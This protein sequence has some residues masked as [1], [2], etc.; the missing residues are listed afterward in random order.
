M[1]LLRQRVCARCEQPF[2]L[3]EAGGKV[4]VFDRD[5]DLMICPFDGCGEPVE[6]AK[7]VLSPNVVGVKGY[8]YF[9]VGLGC[10]VESATHRR[11]IM[12]ERGLVAVDGAAT[13]MAEQHE[14]QQNANAARMAKIKADQER[15]IAACPETRQVL[16]RAVARDVERLRKQREAAQAR[17]DRRMEAR[18]RAKPRSRR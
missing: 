15:A 18:E 2:E 4:S 16:D 9:D 12:A 11:K 13:S 8:P 3:Y 14:R 5:D 10:E 1:P 17:E 6:T 7:A